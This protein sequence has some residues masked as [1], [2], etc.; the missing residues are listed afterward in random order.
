[1]LQVPDVES[2]QFWERMN[3]LVDLNTQLVGL[4]SATSPLMSV[5]K[6]FIKAALMERMAANMMQIFL[7]KPKDCGSADLEPSVAAA[8]F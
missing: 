5:A 4:D 1:M 7:M 6:P 2:P 3:R 8:G